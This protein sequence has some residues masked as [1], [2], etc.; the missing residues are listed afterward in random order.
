MA[1]LTKAVLG[2]FS[3]RIGDTVF[4]QR[5]GKN[6]VGTR[7][8]SYTP[9]ADQGSVDR[10]SRFT[11]SAKL[12]QAVYT[13]PEL[14]AFWKPKTPDGMTIPN[15][16]FQKNVLIVNPDSVSDLTTITPEHSFPI[17]CSS[18][19]FAS[20]AI[21]VSLAAI[22]NAARIDVTKEPNAKLAYV[23]SLTKPSNGTY[24]DFTFISGTSDTK[25]LVLDSAL[26]FNI[27]LSAQDAASIG[28]YADRKILLALLTVDAANAPVEYSGTVVSQVTVTP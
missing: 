15:Y 11:F 28:S 3:G 23:L 7:P 21:A 6:F 12:A 26:S 16:I 14:A 22:G 4:R 13:I 27:A 19:A 8:R 10:R 18:A 17:V 9:P 20:N 2:R 24:P 25:P 1:Q 5:N